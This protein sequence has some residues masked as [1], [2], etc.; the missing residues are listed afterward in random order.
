M[1]SLPAQ[2]LHFTLMRILVFQSLFLVLCFSHASSKGISK[3]SSSSA[4]R[5]PPPLPNKKDLIGQNPIVETERLTEVPR[6]QQHEYEFTTRN[7]E[8]HTMS[9]LSVNQLPLTKRISSASLTVVFFL[10]AW[11]SAS[12]AELSAGIPHS[13]IRFIVSSM[14]QIFLLLNLGAGL[15]NVLLPAAWLKAMLKTVIALNTIRDFLDMVINVFFLV[16]AEKVQ[17]TWLDQAA[18]GRSFFLGRLVVSIYFLCLC[19][20]SSRVRWTHTTPASYPT[21]R[22][23][24][25]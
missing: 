17:G 20:G 15:L 6:K 19:L 3:S 10:L 25:Q 8:Q 7:R 14:M 9:P 16:F 24:R 22:N 5:N 2:E 13:A 23:G 12:L 18:A 4:F 11:R 21:G 1:L